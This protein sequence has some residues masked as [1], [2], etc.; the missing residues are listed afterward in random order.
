M[1]FFLKKYRS[2]LLMFGFIAQLLASPLADRS[3]RSGGVLAVSLLFLLIAGLT[4]PANKRLVRFLILPLAGFWVTARLLEAFGNNYQVYSHASHLAGLA[5]SC[6]ILWALLNRFHNIPQV[7]SNLLAEAF[8]SYLVIANA[9]SQLYSILDRVVVNAFNQAI[10]STQS[11]TLL[12]FSMITL[13]S[14][15]YGGILPI[16]PYVR[17]IAALESMIGIFF[18]AVVVSRLV[19]TS[20]KPQERA[21]LEKA[22]LR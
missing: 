8:I 18:I 19:A 7:A 16:N 4:L 14:V 15:G 13:S 20:R 10:P 11:S 12:Y 9:F 5:L 22:P 1:T 17:L 6:A 2:E 21:E 3:P